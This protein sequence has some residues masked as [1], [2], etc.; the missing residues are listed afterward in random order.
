LL[1]KL[2]NKLKIP[3][4][5]KNFKLVYALIYLPFKLANKLK[6]PALNKNFKC[7][8]EILDLPYQVH[9]NSITEHNGYLP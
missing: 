6:I 9:P 5:N 4:P 8:F 1:L 3:A 7:W 2:P